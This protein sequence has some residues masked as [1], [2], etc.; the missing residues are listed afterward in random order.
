[1]ATCG[2]ISPL[3]ALNYLISSFDSDIITIDYKVRGFTRDLSGKK[4]FIDH[5]ISSVQNYFDEDTLS[6]Y[7][8]TDINVY[9]TNTF[10][11]KL[12]IKEIDLQNYLF[13]TD[14]YEIPPKTRLSIIE[15]LRKEMIE[16]YSGMNIY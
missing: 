13:N 12:L 7:D 1:V 2:E 16:I 4:Y 10:H 15:L 8:A 3:N 11:T 9:Q 6:R 14:A 5:N